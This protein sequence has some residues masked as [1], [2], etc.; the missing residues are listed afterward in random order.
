MK[1]YT[2]NTAIQARDEFIRAWK[3]HAPEVSFGDMTV[4]QFAESTSAMLDV[5]DRIA[6]ARSIVKGL[7][8]ERD[9]VDAEFR[10]RMQQVVRFIQGADAFG[11]D[12]ALY[13]ALGY[14][15]KSERSS[16]LT[17]PGSAKP[18]TPAPGETGG[19]PPAGETGT[20]DAA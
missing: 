19:N 3:Q 12:S 9:H 6:D 5:R 13:R 17:R 15:P 14:V 20:T 16:G 18:D 2:V 11:E 8:R 7:I 1:R 4:D 10:K